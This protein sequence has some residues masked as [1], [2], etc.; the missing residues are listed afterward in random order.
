MQ[1]TFGRWLPL[2]GL[3][4][5]L[6]GAV[7]VGATRNG[8]ELTV[9]QR[10]QAIAR[11]VKC[12]VCVGESVA[13]SKATTARAIFQEIERR[14]GLGQSKDEILVYLSTRYGAQQLLKPPRSGVGGLVWTIPVAVLVV[15]IAGLA[16][17]FRRWKT[18]RPT[19]AL[20]P[21]DEALVAEAMRE[22]S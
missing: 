6:V 4:A 12:P 14:V 18:Q 1:R 22:R 11:E 7:I 20:T 3:L 21:G 5:V 2:L 10:A 16:M 17:A 13:E 15:A 8:P 19:A 9:S